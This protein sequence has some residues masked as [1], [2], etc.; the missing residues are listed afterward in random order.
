MIPAM[1]QDLKPEHIRALNFLVGV[2]DGGNID[3][4]SDRAISQDIWKE[5]NVQASSRIVTSKCIPAGAAWRWNQTK[6]KK[7][8]YVPTKNLSV[9]LIKLIPRRK[10]PGNKSVIPSLKLWQF[11]VTYMEDQRTVTL[12]WC[13]KGEQITQQE[14]EPLNKLSVNF[15]CN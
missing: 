5:G 1:N 2:L 6:S 14:P 10:H 9:A 13:E 4:N 11:T 8:V 7:N 12:L 3:V 15:L